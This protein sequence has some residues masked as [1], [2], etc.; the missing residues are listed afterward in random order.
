MRQ[1]SASVWTDP[2]R[3]LWARIAAH[4]LEPPHPLN[5]T[6]RLARDR[7]WT[8]AFARG[9]VR[10]YRRFCF[11]AVAGPGAATPSEEVDEVWHQ[12]LTYS[13]DYWDVWCG[14]VLQAALHHDP[15]KGG[16]AE[17]RRYREQYAATLARYETYFGPPDPDFWPA[18]HERFRA[19]PR[20]R[21]VDADRWLLVPRPR[22]YFPA[23]PR[24]AWRFPLRSTR[25][26]RP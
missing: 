11:L 4:D 2:L 26:A 16:P 1:A 13:R 23:L 17:Q 14:Q 20:F 5:F 18:T 15:T 7:N 10:E 19:R 3:A 12:H 24:P 6:R 21:I 25:T 9:A 8:L 22:L